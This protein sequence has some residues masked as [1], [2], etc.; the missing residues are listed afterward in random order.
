MKRSVYTIG[1]LVILLIAAFIF[2]LVPIFSGGK[3]QK[4]MPAF[5]SYDGTEIRYEQN[6][7]FANYVAR[8]ADYYKNQGVEINNSNYYYIFSYAFNSTVT[9]LAAKKAVQKSGYKVPKT[10]VNRALMP[11]FTDETG[12]YSSKLYKIALNER[13]AQ[14][15]DMRNELAATLT[16]QRYAEDSFGGQ[17][18]FGKK[19]LYGLKLSDSETAFIEKMGEKQRS[20]SLAVFNMNEYPESE[21]VAYGKANADKF[22][23][24]DLS[25]ITVDDKVKAESVA[26]R[27]ANNEITFAD[28]V[29]QYSNKSYAST[30]S[31]KINNKYQYQ[32]EK[33]L[34]NKDDFETI[35]TLA[36]DAVSAPVKTTVGYTIFRADSEAVQPDFKDSSVINTVYSYLTANEF[37]VIENYYTERAKKFAAAAKEKSFNAA[38]SQFNA[39]KVDVPAFPVNYGDLS[40]MNKLNTSLDGLSG[41]STNEAFIKAAISLKSGEISEPVVNGRNI[42]VLKLNKDNVKPENP[43][44]QEALKDELTNYDAASAQAALLS[45]PKLVNNLSDVFFKYI[46]NNN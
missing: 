35:K 12:N 42:L 33:F 43:I 28:A 34:E 1:S 8:Y 4:R 23:K 40:V 25:V 30:D 44:P 10:A 16:T 17:T 20:F 29:T 14:V 6:T 9:Q 18:P 46:M 36:V 38:V 27:I 7:D 37:S 21:K 13:P 41:A 11:Y 3:A 32:I 31:G 26:K 2:V 24:F 22:V 19:S 5:G 39:K 45:S 15:E